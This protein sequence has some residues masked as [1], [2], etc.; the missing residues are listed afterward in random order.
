M[1]KVIFI[2][3]Y[4]FTLRD[5]H[6][7][8]ADY[9]ADK[10]YFVEIWLVNDGYTKKVNLDISAGLY[11]GKNIYKFSFGEFMKNVKKN[12]N[13]I[14]IFPEYKK[15]RY[16]YAMAR[17]N[18]SYF[19]L[20]GTGKIL[21]VSET[22]NI[23]DKNNTIIHYIVVL[24]NLLARCCWREIDVELAVKCFQRH[25]PQ[26]AFLGVPIEDM[27]L[28]FIPDDK[29]IYIHAFDYDRYL[30]SREHSQN[31]L[32]ECI[33]YI[34]GGF[35]SLDQDSALGQYKD[36]WYGKGAKVANKIE[37]VLDRIEEH[38]H[39]PIVVAGHPHTK[40]AEDVLYK[41]KIIYNKTQELVARCK[42]VIMQW[43]TAVSFVLL[44]KKKILVL[45]DDDFKE[46]NMWN[47]WVLPSYQYFGITPCNM[48][49][50][51][52]AQ[53]PWEYIHKI[54]E[55]TAQQYISEYIKRPGTPD[56]LF[57]EIVED[58]IKEITEKGG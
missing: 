43:S 54:E 58:K 47:S 33:V 25:L 32:E 34:D 20:A 1:Q 38:Y 45:I 28:N 35:G 49:V 42:F 50:E 37:A 19:I 56:K 24:K 51:E 3:N 40:Y 30:E 21:Q 14:Y 5:Y 12:R 27:W 41:R 8:G 2:Y 17:Y 31:V 48:D 26:Y 29:K 7:Y 11:Q 36:P 23:I 10:G 18:C 6:R 52:M 4:M 15:T 57:I 46:Y 16:I 53:M 9:L 55:K 39:L 13:A 44:Y 22:N